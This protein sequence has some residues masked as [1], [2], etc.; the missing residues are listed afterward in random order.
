MLLTPLYNSESLR[1]VISDVVRI[2]LI[3]IIE[4]ITEWLPVSSTGHII[5]FE[6]FFT[7]SDD[8]TD[9]FKKL[10]DYVIQLGAITSVPILFRDKFLRSR[11]SRWIIC[12][13][14]SA[15]RFSRIL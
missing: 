6:R 12:L 5:I 7:L 1:M 8:F 4:G 15:K 10:F 13:K 3:A 2:I 14:V 11:R 9:E